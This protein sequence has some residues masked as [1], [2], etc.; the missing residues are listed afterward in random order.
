MNDF[1]YISLH[2]YILWA[3]AESVR[4]ASELFAQKEQRLKQRL[5]G[6]G[7]D[8]EKETGTHVE[9]PDLEAPATFEIAQQ[10]EVLEMLEDENYSGQ[11]IVS[12]VEEIDP[13]NTELEPDEPLDEK[14][15]LAMSIRTP[16]KPPSFQQIYQK[17][18]PETREVLSVYLTKAGRKSTTGIADLAKMRWVK[19]EERVSIMINGGM[20]LNSRNLSLGGQ[21]M[22]WNFPKRFAKIPK[23]DYLRVWI[24]FQSPMHT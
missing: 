20:K 16:S 7:K 18:Q 23:G 17:V 15:P 24:E 22:I 9:D 6:K 11:S 21:D 5:S 8:V 10:E 2:I 19:N 4:A 3:S 1:C 12:E 13:V 14:L